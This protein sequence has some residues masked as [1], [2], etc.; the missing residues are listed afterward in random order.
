MTGCIVSTSFEFLVSSSDVR[1]Q[2]S[3]V[4][5]RMLEHLG[6]LTSDIRTR[7]S[8]PETRNLSIPYPRPLLRPRA[9]W[10]ENYATLVL[11][12]ELQLILLPV[13]C[14]EFANA[15]RRLCLSL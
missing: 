2:M 7:N 11:I 12:V 15:C 9:V 8:E 14:D 6:L 5:G 1:C 13:G 4:R 10:K 3:D